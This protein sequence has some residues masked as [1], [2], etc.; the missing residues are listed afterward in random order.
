MKLKNKVIVITGSGS[1]LGKCLASKV[2]REGAS[3]AL[4]AR[5]EKE[6]KEVKKQIE[7]DAGTAEYFIC[8]IRDLS[9]IKRTVKKIFQ[10]F[11][12]VDILINNAGIWSDD[13]LEKKDPERRKLTLETNI[14]GNINF[15]YQFLPYFK[16]RNQGYIFNVI[17]SAGY[18]STSSSNVFWKTYGASKWAMTGFTK[19]VRDELQKTKIKVTGFFPGG[20]DSMLYEKSKRPY[21]HNQPWMMKTDDVAD[22]IVFALTRP[23]DV[24]MERIVVSK[25][26]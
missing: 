25:I 15:T 21:S 17:S 9:Q 16:K 14:L 19:A 6:L 18:E 2:A 20:F 22:I 7:K 10:Q 13:E 5:T 26:A 4:V 24:L 1:G 8:D 12:N 23:D 3:V 11:K